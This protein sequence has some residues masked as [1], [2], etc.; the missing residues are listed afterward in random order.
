M[1]WSYKLGESDRKLLSQEVTLFTVAIE[2]YL[3]E[4]KLLLNVESRDGDKENMKH[5][6]LFTMKDRLIQR[7][8]GRSEF[9]VFEKEKEDHCGLVT[10]NIT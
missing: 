5:S 6:Q 1:R 9:G 4:M 3:E 7:P 8:W 10:V 2:G